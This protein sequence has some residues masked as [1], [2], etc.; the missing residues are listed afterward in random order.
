MNIATA[1][2]NADLANDRQR[3]IAHALVLAVA[4]GLN[5][6]DGDAVTGMNA[7]RIKVL[8]RTNDDDVIIFIAHHL[9]LEFLPAVQR[10]FNRKFTGTRQHQPAFCDGFELFCGGD[11]TAAGTAHGKRRTNHRRRRTT[12]FPQVQLLRRVLRFF[13]GGCLERARHSQAELLDNRREFLTRF[14]A[15]NDLVGRANHFAVELLEG[16]VLPQRHRCI[17]CRLSAKRRQHR[18]RTFA[19]NNLT[20]A[21][22]CDRFDIRDVGHL[23]I[24]HDGRRVGVHQ[25]DAIAFFAQRFACLSARIIEFT[26]LADNNGP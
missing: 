6:R 2:F 9:Q 14:G 17:Q 21:F 20:H 26:G 15:L 10:F 18:V 1:G 22:W 12:G 11:Q 16:A 5:R 3:R 4:Q 13:P 23:W 19:L 24:G 25:H 8:N 7:H